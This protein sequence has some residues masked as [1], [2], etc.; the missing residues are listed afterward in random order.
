MTDK[1]T[2][3][4]C[5]I[6]L[7]TR[8]NSEFGIR[9]AAHPPPQE[10]RI[11]DFGFPTHPPPNQFSILNFEFSI[12]HHPPPG[13]DIVTFQGG[14]GHVRR[15]CPFLTLFETCAFLSAE[16]FRQTM[17]KVPPLGKRDEV[18][19]T[20]KS[21]ALCRSEPVPAGPKGPAG[22]R[23]RHPPSGIRPPG[24][25]GAAKAVR[26]R[27]CGQRFSSRQTTDSSTRLLRSV[28]RN[29]MV[30]T[31]ALVWSVDGSGIRCPASGRTGGWVANSKF[32]IR[33]STRW[34]GGN[35]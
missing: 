11:S 4:G 3:A 9:N 14:W 8:A 13:T 1:D 22:G 28:G 25:V 7:S 21:V 30:E 6:L 24:R 2:D 34:V 10:F 18:R 20:S 17:S 31:A 32:E 29:D 19:S 35:S 23:V 12:P 5:R 27:G 15:R 16:R 33:N 26:G